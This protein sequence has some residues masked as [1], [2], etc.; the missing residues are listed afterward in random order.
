[1]KSQIGCANPKIPENYQ[2]QQHEKPHQNTARRFRHRMQSQASLLLLTT[3]ASG[4]Q[5]TIVTVHPSHRAFVFAGKRAVRL[6]SP[7]KRMQQAE[8]NGSCAKLFKFDSKAIYEA[9]FVLTFAIL[10]ARLTVQ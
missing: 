6:K 3:M 7:T 5:P 2:S 1:M 4:Q 9:I 10:C 8:H